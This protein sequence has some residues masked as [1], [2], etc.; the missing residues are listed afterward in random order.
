[1]IF[2]QILILAFIPGFW[3]LEASTDFSKYL[4]ALICAIPSG[5]LAFI[6]AKRAFDEN[7]DKWLKNTLRVH[8]LSLLVGIAVFCFIVFR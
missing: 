7:Q 4:I 2:L 5:H 8:V 3:F 1:M 6:L